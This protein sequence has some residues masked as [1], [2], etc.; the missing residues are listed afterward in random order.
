MVGDL[1]KWTGS[2]AS[3][4]EVTQAELQLCLATSNHKNTQ[5]LDKWLGT[6][7][8]PSDT[9]GSQGF[10]RD[11]GTAAFEALL[12]TFQGSIVKSQFFPHEL[13]HE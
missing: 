7:A 6:A 9:N 11:K 4:P 13:G 8:F 10:P 1:L 3:E 5:P 12:L 2:H